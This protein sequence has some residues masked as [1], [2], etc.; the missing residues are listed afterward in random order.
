MI[1]IFQVELLNNLAIPE[2][3]TPFRKY[4]AME[5]NKTILID[6]TVE[7]IINDESLFE[8]DSSK[9]QCY[10][11]RKSIRNDQPFFYKYVSFSTCLTDCLIN[12]QLKQCGCINHYFNNT[13]NN[14]L[15]CSIGKVRMTQLI[16]F[17]FA[18]TYCDFSGYLCL[19]KL[20]WIKLESV[21]H[22]EQYKGCTHC[23]LACT[24]YRIIVENII[25]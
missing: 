12:L 11:D 20:N 23:F 10:H 4:K 15:L 14:G 25:E 7:P 17:P 8:Y 1:A 21:P 13:V 5:L 9:L 3:I 16:A 2:T 6:Y 24:E 19:N 18:V 22:M